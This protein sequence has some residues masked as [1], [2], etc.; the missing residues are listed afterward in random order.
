MSKRIA[1]YAISDP[2]DGNIRY[3]GQTCRAPNQ[4]LN[5]HLVD[6]R[7]GA[8]SHRNDWLRSV[9]RDGHRPVLN[10]ISWREG[11]NAADERERFW[12]AAFRSQGFDLTN[13]AEGG[14]VNSG[15]HHSQEQRDKWRRERRSNKHPMFG[16]THSDEVKKAS[17]ERMKRIIE[18]RGHPRSGT[19][20]S[21]ETR[22]K[23]KAAVA[24]RRVP[25][26]RIIPE[27]VRHMQSVNASLAHTGRK[28]SEATR[29][30][31]RIAALKR[32]ASKR[33]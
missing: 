10:V 24:F 2:R 13:A 12:I 6:A 9:M 30:K 15:W 22:A 19:K 3:V 14:S 32:E 27:I 7:R 26:Q 31:M 4:R 29:K 1:I 25:R 20:H 33:K 11:Q 28:H 8:S 5:G 16:K 18:E 17:S 23:I 21:E